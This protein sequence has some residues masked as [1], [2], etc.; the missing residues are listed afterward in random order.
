MAFEFSFRLNRNKSSVSSPILLSLPFGTNLIFSRTS[1]GHQH[2][3]VRSKGHS[4]E[5]KASQTPFSFLAQSSNIL[6]CTF[7]RKDPALRLQFSHG[8]GQFSS[9]FGMK[10]KHLNIRIDSKRHQMTFANGQRSGHQEIS[11][12]ELDR[13]VIAEMDTT[14]VL[15]FSCSFSELCHL[16]EQNCSFWMYFPG[17]CGLRLAH[18]RYPKSK[19]FSSVHVWP[20]SV[21]NLPAFFLIF[22]LNKDVVNKLVC[23][24]L[25]SSVNTNEQPLGIWIDRS[26]LTISKSYGEINQVLYINRSAQAGVKNNGKAT[27]LFRNVFQLQKKGKPIENRLPEI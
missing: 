18:R 13:S 27:Q 20:Y 19:F 7:R 1:F 10:L 15:R 6:S 26:A 8:S 14:T 17:F 11:L 22:I 21:F 24:S 9:S 2:Q 4:L 25:E 3:S 12:Q 23:W 5:L 16:P